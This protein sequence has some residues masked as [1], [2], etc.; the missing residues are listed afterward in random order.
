[1]IMKQT[2]VMHIELLAVEKAKYFVLFWP[3]PDINA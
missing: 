1:M 2:A 3:P